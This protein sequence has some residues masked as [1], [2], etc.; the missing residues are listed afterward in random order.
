MDA[1]RL[2]RAALVALQIGVA[3][4]C[5]GAAWKLTL[6]NSSLNSFALMELGWSADS[7]AN[8]DHLQSLVL[9]TGAVFALARPKSL[10]LLLPTL[11]FAIEAAAHGFGH[12]RFSHLAPFA[13]TVRVVA[14]FALVLLARDA[15]RAAAPLLRVA[16]AIVFVAHGI[17]AW[18]RHPAFV[19]LLLAFD[20]TLRDLGLS[21]GLDEAAA[22]Q[23]LVA[24]AV[25]DVIL[26]G[27]LVALPWRAV[28]FWMAIWAGAAAL[29]R[30]VQGGWVLWFEAA[31]RASHATAP[32]ALAFLF[33]ARRLRSDEAPE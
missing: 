13:A 16:V 12:E 11:L 25:H 3:V 27:L 22:R 28:A 23:V 26:A 24:I 18:E 14:P 9:A 33:A 10:V 6:T 8:V 21:V 32:L 20:F 1:P 17:E 29:A 4:Q 7:A 19:D 2:R 5:I 30:V 31:L 15:I